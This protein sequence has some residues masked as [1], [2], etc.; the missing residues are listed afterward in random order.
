MTEFADVDS[1]VAELTPLISTDHGTD[2]IFV[3]LSGED[4]ESNL[5]FLKLRK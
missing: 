4:A 1:P 2:A 5:T 3:R